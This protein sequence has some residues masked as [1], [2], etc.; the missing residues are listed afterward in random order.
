MSRFRSNDPTPRARGLMVRVFAANLVVVA[1]AAVGALLAGW[2]L[3]PIALD[4]HVGMMRGATSHGPGMDVM[5]ADLEA[6]YAAALTQSLGWAALV[7]T[8]AAAGV[9]WVVTVRLL[10]P[11]RALRS[12]TTAFAAGRR[13]TRLDEDAPGEL[14]DVAAA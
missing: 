14:G 11:L 8:V 7:A 1:V 6:A 4:R 5:A 9:A 13:G 10:A 2:A 12:A 3:A